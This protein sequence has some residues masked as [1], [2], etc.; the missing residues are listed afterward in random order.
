MTTEKKVMLNVNDVMDMM[1]ICRQK[2]Y[3]IFN[4]GEF[5]VVKTGRK[6]MV[7]KEVFDAWLK[8]EKVKKRW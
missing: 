5:H 4:C 2:A 7:H 6:Y 3:E 8:G 1:G